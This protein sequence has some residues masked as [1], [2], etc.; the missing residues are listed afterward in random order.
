MTPAAIL[1]AVESMIEGSFTNAKTIRSY[2]ACVSR[3]A[4]RVPPEA[5]GNVAVMRLYRESLSDTARALFGVL[6]SRIED[7]LDSL[8]VPVAPSEALVRGTFVV[9]LLADISNR[10]AVLHSEDDVP[11]LRWGEVSMG[12]GAVLVRRRPLASEDEAALGLVLERVWGGEKPPGDAPIVPLHPDLPRL[13]THVDLVRASINAFTAADS[14]LGRVIARTYTEAIDS[15]MPLAHVESILNDFALVFD[16]AKRRDRERALDIAQSAI[17]DLTFDL[18]AFGAKWDAIK[19]R[20]LTGHL[21][22]EQEARWFKSRNVVER[23]R[24]PSTNP[25]PRPPIHDGVP[26]LEDD[27]LDI[28]Y[29]PPITG[30]TDAFKLS[31]KASNRW[32]ANFLRR[33]EQESTDGE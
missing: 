15:G 21:T 18:E 12:L 2:R 8:D 9:P 3:I 29:P 5:W 16:E 24:E 27:P 6:W 23:R 4:M 28:S 13:R 1:A 33:A 20:V 19:A 25:A 26:M 30:D 10:L 31:L 17:A 7:K 11:T 22:P 32:L 14:T